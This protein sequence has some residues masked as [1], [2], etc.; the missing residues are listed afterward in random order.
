MPPLLG[1]M[2]LEKFPVVPIVPRNALL[3]LLALSLVTTLAPYG[4]P[5]LAPCPGVLVDHLS[6]ER[7][8]PLR[9][10]SLNSLVWHGCY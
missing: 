5:L 6:V 10:G 9:Y 1:G 8:A 3:S 7:E 2:G 4:A